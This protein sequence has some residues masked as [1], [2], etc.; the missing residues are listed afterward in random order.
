LIIGRFF[1]DAYQRGN[2]YYAV[3]NQR[4]VFVRQGL[5]GTTTSLPLRTLLAVEVGGTGPRGT[6]TF[7]NRSAWFAS[8]EW[9]GSKDGPP[10][11]VA[12]EDPTG[13]ANIIRRAI[14]QAA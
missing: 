7:G 10:P 4:L 8:G 5:G 6:I 1:W 3:T 12:I 11:F 2:T 14:Q 13:V 9:P